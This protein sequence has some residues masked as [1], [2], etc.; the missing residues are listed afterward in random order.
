MDGGRKDAVPRYL[1]NLVLIE[2]RYGISNWQLFSNFSNHEKFVVHDFPTFTIVPLG[3]MSSRNFKQVKIYELIYFSL[4]FAK[5]WFLNF[6]ISCVK[7][8]I[9]AEK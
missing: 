6:T 9:S 5:S 3:K 8:N 1:C 2:P 4:L 7:N